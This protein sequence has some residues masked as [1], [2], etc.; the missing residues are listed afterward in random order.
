MP[1][2]VVHAVGKSILFG[3]HAVVYGYPAIAVPIRDL[4]T[5]ATIIPNIRN[6]DHSY[7]FNAPDIGISDFI[8]NL[9]ENNILARA[10]DLFTHA[11]NLKHIPSF[12]L[13]ITS[14]IPVASGL[15]SSASIS[16]AIIRAISQFL[17]LKLS[18]ERVNEF[19]YELEKLHH[20]NPSGIDNTV[21]TYENTLYYVRTK[22][23]QF[24]HSPVPY[25]VVLINS[26]VKSLTAQV[27]AEVKDN[28]EK[29]SQRMNSLFK[30]TG[31]ITEMAKTVFLEGEV[32]KLG[33]LMTE[34]HKILQEI[35][36][37]IPE[38][39]RL[40]K[41]A[42]DCGAYGAKLCGAGKGG[43]VIALMQE[44]DIPSLA[45]ALET[46]GINNFFHTVIQ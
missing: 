32:P 15:G 28:K 24:L 43:N 8:S 17:G 34:N 14:Q 41:I 2:I 5:K 27:V 44:E 46:Q 13:T 35:G 21:V 1:A 40:V 38:L 23:P 11:Y 3:E 36:V 9:P 10:L 19:A 42:L 22:E 33:E 26:G 20:G 18:N 31:N 12:R 16:V 25:H 37:S 7:F 45:Q 4:R 6:E 29:N 30:V 39:D